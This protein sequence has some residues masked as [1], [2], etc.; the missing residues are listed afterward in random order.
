VADVPVDLILATIRSVESGDY[1][2]HHSGSSA[3]GAYQFIDSTWVGAGGGAY[4]PRAYLATPQQQD[5]IARRYVQKILDSHGGDAAAVPE[6]WY[7]GKVGMPRSYVPP[8]NTL[9]VG[10]YIDRWQ[11]ALAKL[12]LPS[13]GI[14]LPNPL[15]VVGGAVGGAA[16]KVGNVVT[17]ALGELA[18]PF[19]AG[20]RRLT[21][22]TVVLGAGMALVVVGA[23]RGVKAG[24]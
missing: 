9:S 8:G 18:D 21:I 16:D 5:T 23:W 3:S 1:A 11:G 13:G 6:V 14:G 10:Q 24:G 22:L 15:E 7:V 20:L 12:V 17:D 4:A 2:N 19:L